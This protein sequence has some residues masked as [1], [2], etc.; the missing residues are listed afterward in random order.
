MARFKL[1]YIVWFFNF[2]WSCIKDA[3]Q[4]PHHCFGEIALFKENWDDFKCRITLDDPKYD[5][6]F[7]KYKKRR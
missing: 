7:D 6:L 4:T 3:V 5:K 1:I 2:V